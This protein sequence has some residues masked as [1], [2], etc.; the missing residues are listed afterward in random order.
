MSLDLPQPWAAFLRELDGLLDEPSEFHCIDGFAVVVAYGLPRSTNDLDY[1]SL[2][3]CNRIPDIQRLAGEGS[4]LARKHKVYVHQVG[5]ACVPESYDERLTELYPG[6][7]KNIRLYVLDPYDLALSKLSRNAERDREDVQYLARTQHLGPD[8]LRERYATE[9]RVALT[10]PLDYHDKTFEFWI[11]AY[12]PQ[13]QPDGRRPPQNA[14]Q[15]SKSHC[16]QGS[17]SET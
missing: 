1:V 12:F 17:N 10:G 11:E 4:P 3:P 2:I 9:L 7:F 8:I 6:E 16:H 5:V 13:S 14:C 15:R